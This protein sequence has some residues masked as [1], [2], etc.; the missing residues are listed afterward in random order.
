MLATIKPCSRATADVG[1]P[2]SSTMRDA[3]T[4][5]TIRADHFRFDEH[6]SARPTDRARFSAP[7]PG[8]PVKP[9]KY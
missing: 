5:G 9:E 1:G 4:L 2:H 3:E 7:P 6:K 8:F